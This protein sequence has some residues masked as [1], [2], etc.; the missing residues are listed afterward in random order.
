MDKH[1]VSGIY[2]AIV[3]PVDDTGAI[4]VERFTRHAR[5]LLRHGCHGL[6]VFAFAVSAMFSGLA[7]GLQVLS[8]EAVNYVVFDA[9][10]SASVVL[11][12]YIGGVGTFLGPALGAAVA[13]MVGIFLIL[14]GLF[15]LL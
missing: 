10:V 8:N 4:S 12:S 15:G 13:T 2:A 3:T 11:N 9:G 7:G 6:G 5:W 14:D 1:Q